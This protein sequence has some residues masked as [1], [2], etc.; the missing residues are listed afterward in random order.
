MRKLHLLLIALTGLLLALSIAWG[1]VYL[2]DSQDSRA[3]AARDGFD[4][5]GRT[6]DA[7]V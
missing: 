1:L 6:A 5:G 7:S 4:R 2:Y 3:D